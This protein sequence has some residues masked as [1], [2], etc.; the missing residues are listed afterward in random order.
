[1]P[2]AANLRSIVG[3]I[4]RLAFSIEKI[5]DRKL[6]RELG[7]GV[8]QFRMLMVIRRGAA[9]RQC[10]IA[11]YWGVAEASVS[12]QIEALR[13]SGLVAP[14]PGRKDHRERMLEL[15][16]KG[17]ATVERALAAME[18]EL[19]DP[20]SSVTARERAKLAAGLQKLLAAFQ[21]GCKETAHGRHHDAKRPEGRGESH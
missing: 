20:L 1:M 8:A 2:D 15:T 12:R 7:F 14:R 17:L 18:T 11:E 19:G 5:A 10:D 3:P 6:R 16:P 4:M 13:E 21:E 9:V